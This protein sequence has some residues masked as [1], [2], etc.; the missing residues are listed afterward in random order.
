[1]RRPSP[2]RSD[3]VTTTA[4]GEARV[5]TS[6]WHYAHWRG[7]FYPEDLPTGQFLSHYTRYFDTVEINNSFYQLPSEATLSNWKKAVPPN[8]LFAVKASSYITHRKKLKDPATSTAR[9]LGRVK[10]LG[11]KLGPVLFQLPPHWQVN[12]RRLEEFL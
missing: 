9:F 12:A 3:R 5:G 1:M 6:G 2:G 10:T 4:H 8:F 11:E 7:V